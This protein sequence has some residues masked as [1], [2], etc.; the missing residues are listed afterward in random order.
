[1]YRIQEENTMK[2]EAFHNITIKEALFHEVEE[3][4]AEVEV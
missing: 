3:D 1:M 2:K 4:L